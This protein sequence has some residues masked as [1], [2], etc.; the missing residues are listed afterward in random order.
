[1][2]IGQIRQGDVTLV[3]VEGV[4]LPEAYS[5]SEKIILAE[6][7]D[8]GHSHKLMS[9]AGVAEWTDEEHGRMVWVLGPDPGALQHEDHD[10][11]PA[12]VV[13]PGVPH[14]VVIQ[15]E[16]DLSGQWR[17]VTD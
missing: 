17:Q 1:M 4:E 11:E 5:I 16:R 6:G 9:E 10:P 13:A 14:R 12:K 3:P 8:T 2:K 15:R 7:E